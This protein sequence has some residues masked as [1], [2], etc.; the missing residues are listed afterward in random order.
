MVAAKETGTGRPTELLRRAAQPVARPEDL[1]DVDQL[2]AAWDVTSSLANDHGLRPALIEFLSAAGWKH[3][4]G[5]VRAELEDFRRWHLLHTLKIAEELALLT[6][7]FQSHGIRFALF[8]GAALS[9]QLYGRLAAREYNDLDLIVPAADVAAAEEVLSAGGYRPAFPE[10]RFRRFFQ[11]HQGQTAFRREGG[12]VDLDLHWTFS[13]SFLPFPL[14]E[15]EIWDRLTSVPVAGVDVPTLSPADTVLLLAGHGTK[16]GWRSLMWLRD[17]AFAVERWRDLDW[18]DIHRRAG[19]NGCGDS[20]LLGCALAQQVLAT[21]V[22]WALASAVGGSRRVAALAA[23][24]G[25]RLR[26]GRLDKRH[27]DDLA[28]CDRRVDRWRAELGFVLAPTPSDFGALPLPRALWPA[29]YLLRPVR[30]M[31]KAV[32]GTLPLP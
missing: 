3:V 20:V 15:R 8:K 18:A 25:E 22:P 26:Q 21:P 9:I 11:G 7:T 4:P 19:R 1:R 14:R 16:E 24:L 2:E 31:S 32:R 6:H 17:F 13:G 29:Y 5:S 12:T 30:L 10:R 27:L 23:S 28:L